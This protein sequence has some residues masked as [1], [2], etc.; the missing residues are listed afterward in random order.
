MFGTNYLS[1]QEGSF[2]ETL[3]IAKWCRYKLKQLHLLMLL[4]QLSSLKTKMARED[5]FWFP[6]VKED[7]RNRA[8]MMGL[9][10]LTYKGRKQRNFNHTM[11]RLGKD[12]LRWSCP[13]PMLWARTSYTR[14]GC[15]GPHQVWPWT[16]PGK[17]PPPPFQATY[18]SD[19]VAYSL[20][21]T[22]NMQHWPSSSH[23]L[24]R[25]FISSL[26]TVYVPFV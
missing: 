21:N 10:L 23:H 17:G 7:W 2:S 22:K 13:T 15:S 8:N 18:L 24:Y 12:S 14:S 6:E 25:K 20:Q 16:P 11:H 5:D 9:H 19:F 26:Y 3:L 4:R 1:Y